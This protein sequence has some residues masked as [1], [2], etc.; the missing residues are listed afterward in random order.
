VTIIEN[1]HSIT[2]YS[3]D[4]LLVICNVNETVNRSEVIWKCN[5]KKYDSKALNEK[6]SR[7]DWLFDEDEV[8]DN[9]N[10]F[11]DKLFNTIDELIPFER[12]INLVHKSEKTLL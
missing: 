11:E 10:I 1:I 4:H 6:L 5:W 8:Q 12:S 3:G 9:W 2:P 7:E